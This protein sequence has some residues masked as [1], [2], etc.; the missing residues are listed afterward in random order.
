MSHRWPVRKPRPVLQQLEPQ[1]LLWTGER[2]V[3]GFFPLAM[4]GKSAYS[5]I[6]GRLTFSSGLMNHSN[7]D[8][9]VFVGCAE[10]GTEIG[11]RI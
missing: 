9:V 10:K 2:V 11:D 3:D 4:G 5:G 6:V 7:N 1:E 8:A